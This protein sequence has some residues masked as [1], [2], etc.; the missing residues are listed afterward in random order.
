MREYS[1]RLVVRTNDTEPGDRRHGE[2][3]YYSDTEMPLEIRRWFDGALEDRDDG[4]YIAW[5]EFRMRPTVDN[6][7]HRFGLPVTGE[8]H[9]RFTGCTVTWAEEQE[10]RM[11][12][13]GT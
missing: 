10:R 5:S 8:D 1:V 7:E 4:P 2:C 3:P 12:R 11:D 13:R 9:C 6:H